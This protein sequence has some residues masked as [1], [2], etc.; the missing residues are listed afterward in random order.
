MTSMAELTSSNNLTEEAR[1]ARG[2][3]AFDAVDT[4]EVGRGGLGL[5]SH[6]SCAGNDDLQRSTAV[7]VEGSTRRAI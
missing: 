2:R 7:T 6:R 1:G 4:R 5:G 3:G